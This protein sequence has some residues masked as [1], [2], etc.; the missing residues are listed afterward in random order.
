M[1]VDVPDRRTRN[2]IDHF[3]I[4]RHRRSSLLDVS[5]FRGAEVN[6]DHIL[7]VAETRIDLKAQKL[8]AKKVSKQF[9][10]DTLEDRDKRRR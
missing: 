9:D 1:H 10:S 5:G 3:L 6:S 8:K 4:S 2:Q 7:E